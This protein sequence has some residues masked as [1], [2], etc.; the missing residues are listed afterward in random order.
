LRSLNSLLSKLENNVITVLDLIQHRQL[1]INLFEWFNFPKSCGKDK[2][3]DL[4]YNLA[5][6]KKKFLLKESP[7]LIFILFH[8]FFK[9]ETSVQIIQEI[10]GLQFLNALKNDI[11][12]DLKDKVGKI[13]ERLLDVSSN[14]TNNNESSATNTNETSNFI[15]K[16]S[17]LNNNNNKSASSSTITIINDEMTPRNLN[18]SQSVKSYENS[19]NGSI[20]NGSNYNH[21]MSQKMGKFKFS[22]KIY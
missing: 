2:I 15:K 7:L 12:D 13:I 8:F 18:I 17:S 22:P 5:N 6:V 1:F 4:L 20:I 21:Q 19:Y 14:I 11:N 3:L 9:Y 16:L 10:G